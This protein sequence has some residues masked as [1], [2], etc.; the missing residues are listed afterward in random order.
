MS[1]FVF[2]IL[3]LI[4]MKALKFSIVILFIATVV[5]LCIQSLKLSSNVIGFKEFT[6]IPIT[7]AFSL[8]L[9]L[10]IINMKKVSFLFLIVSTLILVL[11]YFSI[12]SNES[13]FKMESTLLLFFGAFTLFNIN[14]GKS[15]IALIVYFGTALFFCLPLILENSYWI[16]QITQLGFGISTTILAL[17]SAFKNSI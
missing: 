7:L 5:W 3:H 8:S 2:F 17:I 14:K 6:L 11:G 13:L 9:L 1:R 4:E 16:L 12:I 15:T 10:F